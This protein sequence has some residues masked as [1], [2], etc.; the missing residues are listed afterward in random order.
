MHVQE[1]FGTPVARRNLTSFLEDNAPSQTPVDSPPVSQ[2]S[3]PAQLTSHRLS[4]TEMKPA[5]AETFDVVLENSNDMTAQ[6]VRRLGLV[7]LSMKTCHTPLQVD[8]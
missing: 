6:Q 4:D 5:P 7:A 1:E 8:A 3:K 2:P